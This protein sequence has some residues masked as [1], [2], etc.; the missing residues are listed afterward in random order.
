MN[1]PKSKNLTARLTDVYWRFDYLLGGGRPPTRS[2]RFCARHPV[3]V[4]VLIGLA[5]CATWLGASLHAGNGLIKSVLISFSVGL[6]IGA[7]FTG[8]CTLERKRQEK[9]FRGDG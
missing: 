6:L 2:Q 7:L 4:G 9:R 8:T 5:L 3:L 1:S